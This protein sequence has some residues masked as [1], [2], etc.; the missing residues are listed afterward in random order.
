MKLSTL[1]KTLNT[2]SGSTDG[3][4]WRPVRPST[5]ENTF[6]LLRI[7]AAWKVLAGRADAIEWDVSPAATTKEPTNER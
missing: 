4:T 5:A 2:L 1:I 3:R 7:K 6:L